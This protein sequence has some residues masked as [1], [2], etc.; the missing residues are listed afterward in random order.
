MATTKKSIKSTTPTTKTKKSIKSKSVETEN[1]IV[2]KTIKKSPKPVSKKVESKSSEIVK[3]KE[4]EP[5]IKK[6]IKRSD[7]NML[8]VSILLWALFGLVVIG[9]VGY[10]N[11]KNSVRAV[12]DYYSTNDQRRVEDTYKEFI[13]EE[14]QSKIVMTNFDLFRPTF[15]L[16]Q[17]STRNN[18]QIFV[19]TFYLKRK[20]PISFDVTKSFRNIVSNKDF[21]EAVKLAKKQDLHLDNPDENQT[22]IISVRDLDLTPEQ[23]VQAE[24]QKAAQ[25]EQLRAQQEYEALPNEEKIERLKQQ[26]A[27]IQGLIAAIENGEDTY[28]GEEIPAISVNQL[29][30]ILSQTQGEIQ[31]LQTEGN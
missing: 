11:Y 6:P 24:E 4:K 8:G 19:E 14:P 23:Q 28:N 13:E 18:E 10:L 5:I 9:V 3:D 21:D 15:S 27:E 31:R 29:N 20:S 26:S 2:K 1:K 16:V 25:E 17:E 12:N 22:E 7:S 30:D